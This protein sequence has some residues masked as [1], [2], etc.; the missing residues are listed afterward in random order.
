M[1]IS[2]ISPFI[3]FKNAS[4]ETIDAS[5]ELDAKKLGGLCAA[6]VLCGGA[7]CRAHRVGER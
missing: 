6:A 5:D 4:K 7:V 1:A 2:V 3:K